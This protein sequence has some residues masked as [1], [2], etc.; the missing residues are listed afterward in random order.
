MAINSRR[1]YIGEIRNTF[2]LQGEKFISY[3]HLESRVVQFRI[4]LKGISDMTC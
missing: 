1:A 3:N 2:I 4:I